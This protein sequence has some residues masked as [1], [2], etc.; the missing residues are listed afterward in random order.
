MNM[1]QT[2]SVF[3]NSLNRGPPRHRRGDDARQAGLAPY[4]ATTA[5]HDGEAEV[6]VAGRALRGSSGVTTPS[7]TTNLSASSTEISSSRRSACGT[8]TV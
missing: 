3:E 7:E 5:S 8:I 4:A 2:L 1:G 6:S